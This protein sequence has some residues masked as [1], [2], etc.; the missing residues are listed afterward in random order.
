MR[1]RKRIRRDKQNNGTTPPPLECLHLAVQMIDELVE[2]SLIYQPRDEE[3]RKWMTKIEKKKERS[4]AWSHNLKVFIPFSMYFSV[5]PC[6]SHFIH[7]FFSRPLFQTLRSLSLVLSFSF[8]LISL[9]WL[10]R[11]FFFVV[12]GWRIS[13]GR[14]L[15][16]FQACLRF[17]SIVRSI[18]SA[19]CRRRVS[20][21]GGRR[22]RP[23]CTRWCFRFSP[24]I[25]KET[26]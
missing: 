25:Q 11:S 9:C 23:A 15:Q 14:L 7:F 17:G 5:S 1:G 2:T 20:R 19:S 18:S 26:P 13:S 4:L 24:F 3:R 10:L 8:F 12:S 6:I 22:R 21:G 16:P